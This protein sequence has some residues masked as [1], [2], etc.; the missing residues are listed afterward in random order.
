MITIFYGVPGCGKTSLY[1]SIV[2]INNRKR[3]KYY[4]KLSKSKLHDKLRL[5][6]EESINI[7]TSRKMELSLK[8]YDRLTFKSKLKLR[9]I[10]VKCNSINSL[11]DMLYKKNFYD[12][13]YC[14][15]ETIQ[16]T[17]HFDIKTLGKFP[18]TPN[19]LFLLDECGILLNNRQWKSLSPEAKEM[20]AL[21]RHKL[22]DICACSQTVDIDSSLRNRAEKLFHVF[23]VG[24]FT[25]LRRIVYQ[26][27]VNEN[28]E[29]GDFYTKL[30][31][32]QWLLELIGSVRKS[33]RMAKE[34][35]KSSY[36][37]Y[38]PFYYKYFNSYNDNTVYTE[39]DPYYEYLENLDK[40]EQIDNEDFN[41]Y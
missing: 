10:I 8:Y 5:L 26:V 23:R 35:W 36:F 30:P 16:G 32:L 14:T 34:R 17:V 21:H 41:K 39:P 33:K 28:H 7:L 25:V 27:D 2:Q 31:T 22:V 24:P 3:E 9:C 4:K 20:F 40:K 1:T 11:H 19:S 37:I 38:R 12:V 18:P 6:N 29:L 13:I 15:D